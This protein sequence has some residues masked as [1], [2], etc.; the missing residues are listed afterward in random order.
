VPSITTRPALTGKFATTLEA[1][2]E[3]QNTSTAAI[4]RQLM[5]NAWGENLE[6]AP[7]TSAT[8]TVM[9]AMT[10]SHDRQ[11]NPSTTVVTPSVAADDLFAQSA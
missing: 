8:P 5:T 6:N 9:T 2:A 4:L 3:A 11:S 7:T 1:V 10:D